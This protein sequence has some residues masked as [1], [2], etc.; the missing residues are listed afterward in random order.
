MI[1]RVAFRIPR[2]CAAVQNNAERGSKMYK[3]CLS[4]HWT[5]WMAVQGTRMYAFDLIIIIM[6]VG[7]VILSTAS[8]N[9][10]WR[11]LEV[12]PESCNSLL[13]Y[14][15]GAEPSAVAVKD[16][17]FVSGHNISVRL[18]LDTLPDF[19]KRSFEYGIHGRVNLSI[20]IVPD[21]LHR[22]CH[23]K[24]FRERSCATHRAVK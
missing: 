17:E 24:R 13:R 1:L 7:W 2:P 18:R 5:K 23:G 14:P 16:G 4:I 10:G 9:F 15:E 19:S 22:A 12:I 21:E 8:T 11:S 6:F 20:F 3:E